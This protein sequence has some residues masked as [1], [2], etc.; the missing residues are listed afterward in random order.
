MKTSLLSSALGALALAVS[1]QATTAG[2]QEF[3]KVNYC[4]PVWVNFYGV[5][6]QPVIDA[7]GNVVRHAGSMPCPAAAAAGPATEYLV[8]FDWDRSKITPEASEILKNAAAAAKTL[9]ASQVTVVGHTDTSGSPRYNLGLSNRRSAAVK[10]GLVGNGVAPTSISTDGRGETQL[11]VQT[12][13]GVREPSN[14]RAEI[15]LIK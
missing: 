6:K 7:R 12:K 4:N 2:A 9:N 11:L 3:K 8:F 13:D 10:D 14:R 15:K 5:G 1:F